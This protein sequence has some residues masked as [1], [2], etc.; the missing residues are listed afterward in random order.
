[1]ADNFPHLKHKINSLIQEAQYILNKI[2]K[3]KSTFNSC[4]VKLENSKAKNKVLVCLGRK[5]RHNTIKNDTVSI[6]LKRKMEARRQWHNIFNTMNKNNWQTL[7]LYLAKIL[8][9][10]RVK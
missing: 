9:K 4:I 7:I 8:F 5:D 10:I 1:M 6:L 2:N 3:K